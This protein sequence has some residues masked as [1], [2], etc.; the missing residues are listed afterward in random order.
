MAKEHGKIRGFFFEIDGDGETLQEGL[1]NFGAALGRALAGPPPRIPKP[2]PSAD[3]R[4]PSASIQEVVPGEDI[5][6]EVEGSIL[7]EGAGSSRKKKGSSTRKPEGMPSVI[8]LD[9][10]GKNDVTLQHFANQKKPQGLS[11]RCL[12]AASWLKNHA[13]VDEVTTNHIFTCFKILDWTPHPSSYRTL[14]N[15]MKQKQKSLDRGSTAGSFK[16]NLHGENLVAKM[17][18]AS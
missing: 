13:D 18:T 14:M 3:V 17:G 16:I 8:E 12:L 9:L 1:R 5:E 7:E 2:L 15:D 4:T 11:E 10:T 6:A